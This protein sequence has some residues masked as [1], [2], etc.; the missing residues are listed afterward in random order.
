MRGSVPAG[1]YDGVN[2][3]GLFVCLHVVL[4]D[5]PNIARPGVPFHLIPRILLEACA[6]IDQFHGPW[7]RS[8]FDVGNTMPFG[9]PQDWIL[10]LGPR[11][12]RVHLKDYK[13]GKQQALGSL[14][15]MIMKSSK[16]LSAAA[17]Q[18]RLRERLT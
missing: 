8:H 9:Y 10:T 13:A 4:A 1:R 16:G 6:F 5:E 2:D 3:A 17:V 15:G 12:K 7:V 11:I 14:V 18:A